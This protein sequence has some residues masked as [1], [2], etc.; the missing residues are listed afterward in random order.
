MTRVLDILLVEP[1]SEHATLITKGIGRACVPCHVER[2]TEPEEA[3]QFV[4]GNGAAKSGGCRRNPSLIIV[5]LLDPR[6]PKAAEFMRWLRC[7][8]RTKHIPVIVLGVEG[9]AFSVTAAYGLGASSYLVKP[10]DEDSFL[11]MITVAAR[12]WTRFNLSPE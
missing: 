1:D 5:E 8:R 3:K 7:H 12:Y 10:K 2:V 6:R 11:E 9:D 4:E